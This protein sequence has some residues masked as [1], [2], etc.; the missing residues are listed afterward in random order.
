MLARG[1]VRRCPNCGAGRLFRRWT[2]MRQR[3][4]R[5]GYKFEREQGF[6]VGGMAINIVVTEAVF[7]VF[8]VVAVVVTL[9]DPPLGLLLVAGLV[10]NLIVPIAFYPF[11][12]TI[13]AAVELAMRPLEE[14]ELRDAEAA[15]SANPSPS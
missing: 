7:L 5:C 3:C 13:W 14:R 10:I 8:L 6:I 9:P 4:P 2:Q 15:R 1:L 12:K 11:S